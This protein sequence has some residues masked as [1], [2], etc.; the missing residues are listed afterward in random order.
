MIIHWAQNYGIY[1]NWAGPTNLGL[2]TSGRFGA[3][4]GLVTPWISRGVDGMAPGLT[5]LVPKTKPGANS[6]PVMISGSVTEVIDLWKP[7]LGGLRVLCDVCF[8]M[9]RIKLAPVA[10]GCL[11]SI[12]VAG[13]ALGWPSGL[14]EPRISRMA[15]GMDGLCRTAWVPILGGFR[16]QPR[17]NQAS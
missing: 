1:Q 17:K 5:Y 11:K 4:R 2:G 10:P 14:L 16:A 6:T 8:S 7:P 15:R 3:Y 12:L 13:L 9:G